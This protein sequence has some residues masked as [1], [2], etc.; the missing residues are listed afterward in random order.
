MADDLFRLTVAEAGDALT[1]GD[2]S[3]V[4]LTRSVLD[5]IDA[6]D[7]RTGA[8]LLV[9]DRRRAG[10]GRGG[11]CAACAR[12]GWP[13]VGH[14]AG[15]QGRALH[16]RGHDHLRVAHP[17]RLRAALRRHGR[18]APQGRRRRARGQDEH[19]RVR[20]GVVEREFG[21]SP[22]AQSVGLG[23]GAGGIERRIG[24][25]G[26]GGRVSRRAWLGH[27]RKRAAARGAVWVRGPQA[28]L[29]SRVALWA[30]GVRVV[31]RP[32]RPA[33]EVGP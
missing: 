24:G 32:G 9:T 30:G 8:Y 3:S 6:V 20:H 14:P 23:E 27:R 4:D 13:A 7:T 12:R 1:A 17:R 10:S 18:R 11:G 33:N 31:A 21:L 25:G 5:R 22:G 29:R 26:G 28:H 16:R 19:G 15:D 2:I